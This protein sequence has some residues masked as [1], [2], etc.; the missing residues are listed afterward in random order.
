MKNTFN[1]IK[2][3]S[4]L[5][6]TSCLAL[7]SCQDDDTIDKA[8]KPGVTVTQNTITVTEGE[9][10][11]FDFA[12]DYT[13]GEKIDIRIDVLDENGNIVPTTQPVGDPNSGNGYS[14]LSF[15]DFNVPY[16]TWFDAGWFQYGY[17]GG[18]GYV[19]TF[20][21][22]TEN[23]QINIETIQDLIPEGTE[24]FSFRLSATSLMKVIIDEVITVNVENYVSP[25]PAELV[26]RLNWEGTFVSGGNNVDFCD[27]DMDLELYDN[28]FAIVDTSYTDCPEE[29][30]M[31][32]ATPD[33][34]YFF[35]PSLWTTGGYA[36]AV[37]IP[38]VLTIAKPGTLLET[39]DLSAD[40]PMNEGGLNDGNGNAAV[41]FTINKTGNV[42]TINDLDNNTVFQGRFADLSNM[43]M[44]NRSL[45]K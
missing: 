12:L 22:Y 27:I 11:T 4:F 1:N 16:N 31:N 32:S 40:F 26:L 5:A 15:D 42:Y 7:V 2:R 19:A 30:V 38:A 36:E 37:N 3:V 45:E 44:Q 20:P 17:L 23:F 41:V 21:A 6:L 39:V 8:G 35:V 33:G 24:S 29:I 14:R 25:D 10:A 13:V 43:I 28:T 34:D 18:S 9:T